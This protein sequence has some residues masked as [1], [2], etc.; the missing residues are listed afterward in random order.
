MQCVVLKG[1]TTLLKYHDTLFS[2]K[3]ENRRQNY[4]KPMKQWGR[5]Y[6]SNTTTYC[7]GQPEPQP[8]PAQL[9]SI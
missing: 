7:F 3:Q 1:Y 8:N 5:S 6:S 9:K 4:L 2:T